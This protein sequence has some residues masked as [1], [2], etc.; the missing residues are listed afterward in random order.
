MRTVETVLALVVVATVVASFAKRLRVPPPSLLVVAGVVFG[1]LPGV[2]TIRVTP[3][4]VSLL[5]LP[6]LL[7]AAGEELPWRDLRTVWRPVSVLAIGLVLASAVA[8][9]LVAVAITPMPLGMCFVLG[10]VLASTDPIAVTALGRKLALPPRLQALV[11]AESLFNDATSLLLFRVA[12][13]VTVAG[14]A[15]SWPGAVEDVIVL[16]CGGVL[17]GVLVALGAIVTRRRTED[18]VL[19]SVISLVTP[20]T[21]FVLAEAL[22]VSGVTAVVVSSVV[23]GTQTP[24]LT[25]AHGR[26]QLSAVYGTLIFILEIGVFSLIGLQLPTLIR[27]QASTSTQWPLQALAIALTLLLVRIMWIFPLSVLLQRRGGVRRPSWQVPAVLSW[28]GAR[29]VVPL[30][31]ALSIPVVTADGVPLPY[32]ELVLLLSTAV[33][34][35]TLVVQGFTLA[36]LVR[37]A[38]IALT[39]TSMR[40][41]EIRA[42]LRLAEAGLAHLEEISGLEIAPEW[43]I[44]ELR[45]S[46]QARI[47]RVEDSL[48]QEASLNSTA[49][50]YRKMRRALLAMESVELQ[51]LY[52]AGVISDTTRKRIQ[53]TLDMEEAGLHDD[54]P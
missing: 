45:R 16:A 37:L 30:A 36:P 14:S 21:G 7:F 24:R 3:E 9:G 42:R 35:I 19:E 50:L 44:Q 38:G 27:E 49:A 12:L 22:H 51:R 46:W 29:G 6:P 52:E 47:K 31:A 8:V 2:P 5:V 28:A 1:L 43:V 40:N 48:G 15:M 26:L 54:N 11:Q 39:P 23:L 18:P 33:I 17:V 34:V 10:A 41:E 4:I 25:S 20:Y 13:S 32:R 53:R